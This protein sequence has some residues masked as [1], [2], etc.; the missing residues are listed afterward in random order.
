MR[1]EF[2]FSE[3]QVRSPAFAA[4]WLLAPTEALHSLAHATVIIND[5]IP[6]AVLDI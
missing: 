5:D 2:R 1:S 3:F 4:D 6:R